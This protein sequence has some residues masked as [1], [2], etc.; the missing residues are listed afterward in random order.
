[1]I[2]T[3]EKRPDKLKSLQGFKIDNNDRAQTSTR[4]DDMGSLA[5]EL[6]PAGAPSQYDQS[7][8][9]VELLQACDAVAEDRRIE[10]QPTV[11]QDNHGGAELPKPLDHH[12]VTENEAPYYWNEQLYAEQIQHS[13]PEYQNVYVGGR[14]PLQHY[15][16]EEHDDF[17][18]EDLMNEEIIDDNDRCEYELTEDEFL[19]HELDVEEADAWNELNEPNTYDEPSC[20][21]SETAGIGP[22]DFWRPNKLY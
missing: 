21:E 12:D 15:A 17:L 22:V 9:L 1:M 6:S 13:H 8:S 16:L 20:D 7:K 14:H 2:S 19:Y 18:D 10:V 11:V 5:P 3:N 4:I